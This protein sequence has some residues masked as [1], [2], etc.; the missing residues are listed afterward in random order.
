MRVFLLL[1]AL[2]A[3]FPAWADQAEDFL[4][5]LC[6]KGF[7][8]TS[9]PTGDAQNFCSCVRKDISP[10]LSSVQR[11]TLRAAQEDLLKN[12]KPDA[13]GL[14]ES[15]V[16]DL[17]VA[18]QARCEQALYPPSTPV[19]AQAGKL[20]MTLRCNS[21][22]SVPE[23]LI[24][25][26]NGQ[27]LSE[28][29]KTEQGKKLMDDPNFMG[30]FATVSTVIDGIRKTEKWGIDMIG[31]IVFPEKPH[32]L[33]SALRSAK[34]FEVDIKRGTNT[35]A[36]TFQMTGKISPLWNPCGAMPR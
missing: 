3:S 29:E 7:Q 36:G 17:V 26:R 12:R 14:S 28:K 23:A 27:L 18:A 16:R 4:I 13:A 15:G 8:M 10:R 2:S 33:I 11:T 25:I 6:M 34:T 30:Y 1:V 35:Y 31:Q 22:T 20:E 5:S 21:D 19:H 24:Y 9:M 32:E